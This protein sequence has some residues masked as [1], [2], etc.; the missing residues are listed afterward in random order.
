MV[1]RDNKYNQGITRA[2][3]D[4]IATDLTGIQAEPQYKNEIPFSNLHYKERMYV[5]SAVATQ[6]AIP[7]LDDHLE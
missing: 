3:Q 4:R 6:P 5:A 7:I 2:D 1:R